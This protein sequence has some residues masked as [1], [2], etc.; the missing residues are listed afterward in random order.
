MKPNRHWS[1]QVTRQQRLK[2]YRISRAIEPRSH[3]GHGPEVWQP[4]KMGSK[5]REP[6]RPQATGQQR[7][8]STGSIDPQ[9]HSHKAS[10]LQMAMGLQSQRAREPES[11]KAMELWRPE[12]GSL[13]A[14][15]S[16]IC[17]PAWNQRAEGQTA[18]RLN[19]HEANRPVR[20]WALMS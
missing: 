6:G 13:A 7:G 18:S 17:R 2:S 4:S 12:G 9:S 16:A 14:P 19:R 11:Q 10:M 20:L 8:R 3:K 1:L 5:A 15:R